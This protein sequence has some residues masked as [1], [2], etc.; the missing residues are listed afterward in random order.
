MQS[1]VL[2]KKIKTNL[3]FKVLNWITSEN[4]RNNP[5]G[6]EDENLWHDTR[7]VWVSDRRH[8]LP[9]L[10]WLIPGNILNFVKCWKTSAVSTTVEWL[11]LNFASCVVH[12]TRSHNYTL[13]YTKYFFVFFLS[14]GGWVK[15]KLSSHSSTYQ[16]HVFRFMPRSRCNNSSR[17]CYRAREH[18]DP[19]F[20]R[21]EFLI[22]TSQ[23]KS[24]HACTR[25]RVF[26][27]S[28]S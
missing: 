27:F 11:K 3:V 13:D 1:Y 17:C 24:L 20:E 2:G 14:S 5:R 6:D 12:E 18:V 28:W 22:D 9:L 8:K 10:S 26:D 19:L 7:C 16:I 25:A 15:I 21:S 4:S 23:K